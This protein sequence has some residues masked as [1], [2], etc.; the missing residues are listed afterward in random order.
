MRLDTYTQMLHNGQIP[1]EYLSDTNGWLQEKHAAADL[2][3]PLT[4]DTNDNTLLEELCP[5]C[6][7]TGNSYRGGGGHYLSGQC[8]DPDIRTALTDLYTAARKL[9]S[10]R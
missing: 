6:L 7:E 10:T 2:N 3:H 5:L 4:N 1:T 9:T 8:T